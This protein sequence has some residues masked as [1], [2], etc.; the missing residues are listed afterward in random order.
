MSISQV[1][2]WKFN[3]QAGMSCKEIDGMMEII[4]FPGGIPSKADQ[5]DWTAEFIAWEA[6]GGRKDMQ[7]NSE[8]TGV[9]QT[10]IEVLII[11]I[12]DGTITTKTAD[13]IINQAK[14]KRKAQL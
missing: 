1:I 6:S 7:V 12:Q 9:L 10:A 11:A 2:G 8:F 3:D 4:G 13:D 5:A 14:A